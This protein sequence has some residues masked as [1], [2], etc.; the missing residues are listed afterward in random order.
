MIT[1]VQ[2]PVCKKPVK[3]VNFIYGK[4]LKEMAR[5]LCKCKEVKHDK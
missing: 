1:V 2:C 5:E 4:S 3:I